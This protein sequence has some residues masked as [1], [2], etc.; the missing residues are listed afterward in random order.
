VY[1]RL[2]ASAERTVDGKEEKVGQASGTINL[3]V[4]AAGLMWPRHFAVASSCHAVDAM[5]VLDGDN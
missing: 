3:I 4:S 1:L 5:S 2:I